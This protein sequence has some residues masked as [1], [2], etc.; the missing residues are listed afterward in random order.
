MNGARDGRDNGARPGVCGEGLD[1]DH[2][3][4]FDLGIKEP[5]V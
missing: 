4:A 5:P 3:T 2:P 1:T